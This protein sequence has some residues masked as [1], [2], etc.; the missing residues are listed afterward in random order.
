M[1][2]PGGT[3]DHPLKAGDSV[4]CS[5]RVIFHPER[6]FR[7]KRL[8]VGLLVV[9]VALMAAAAM[10]GEKAAA[11]KAEKAAAAVDVSNMH[12]LD[13]KGKDAYY[14]TCGKDCKC[15]MPEGDAAKCSCGKPITTVDIAGKYYC[16]KCHGG[17]TDKAGKC[18]VCGTELKKAE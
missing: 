13:I 7:M 1:S 17:I 8:L 5:V 6:E 2:C 3:P 11:K 15:T 9:G 12:L 18:S 14:C 4:L 16:P 10:A